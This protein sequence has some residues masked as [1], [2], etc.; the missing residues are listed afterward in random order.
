MPPGLDQLDLSTVSQVQDRQD[1]CSSMRLQIEGMLPRLI[2]GKFA[3][4]LSRSRRRIRL[5]MSRSSRGGSSQLAGPAVISARDG[6]GAV[7]DR[8]RGRRSLR[9]REQ[10]CRA[11]PEV[12]QVVS[13]TLKLFRKAGVVPGLCRVKSNRSGSPLTCST[14]VA[15][16]SVNSHISRASTR[17]TA[18][19]PTCS[20]WCRNIVV[21]RKSKFPHPKPLR[22]V[23]PDA[24][25]TA[26]LLRYL[27]WVG[28]VAGTSML[29]AIFCFA[30]TLWAGH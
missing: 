3:Q 22:T 1:F 27:T 20:Q 10:V 19:S 7:E 23:T 11:H 21:L 13:E 26:R 16:S 28:L 18:E 30:L 29:V 14:H 24:T 4:R 25:F 2:V 8:P 17:N 9:S 12:A 6:A 5:E 15:A